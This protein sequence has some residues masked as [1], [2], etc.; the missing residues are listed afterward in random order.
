ME[1]NR[2]KIK[3]RYKKFFSGI[4]F[5]NIVS[6]IIGAGILGA[7]TVGTIKVSRLEEMYKGMAV[8]TEAIA[9]T[10]DISKEIESTESPFLILENKARNYDFTKYLEKYPERENYVRLAKKA[11][12]KYDYIWH[13]DP[14]LILCMGEQESKFKKKAISSALAAGSYQFIISTAK[15]TAIAEGKLGEWGVYIPKKYYEWKAKRGKPWPFRSLA[16]YYSSIG[17]HEQ[18]DRYWKLHRH[19]K[20]ESN[21]LL[22]EC[23]QEIREAIAGKTQEE[24]IKIHWPCN[25]SLATFMAV[26]YLA[27]SFKERK[28]DTREALSSY[29]AGMGNVRKYGGI[30]PL[31]E[32]VMY[33]NIII[34]N[35]KRWNPIL[36]VKFPEF[37]FEK[38][39]EL[40]IRENKIKNPF[41]SKLYNGI[42]VPCLG[43]LKEKE[44]GLGFTSTLLFPDSLEQ[45]F[46]YDAI[47][48]SLMRDQG[49]LIAPHD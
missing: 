49:T 37:N 17:L 32:T 8:A 5:K 23:K 40:W 43:K 47:Y 13:A 16:I 15:V 44:I 1:I 28:G 2:N 46:Q 9:D 20:N 30:P 26:K 4:S 27:Y 39:S 10:I 14:L 11:V 19:Y 35:W 42:R 29:N 21:K 48:K 41:V 22:K 12:K 34:N 45:L 25:D 6:W 38:E 36:E 18:S 31:R 24:I 7:L 33:Q 3:K